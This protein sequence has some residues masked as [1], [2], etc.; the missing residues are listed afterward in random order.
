MGLDFSDLIGLALTLLF[1][2][3]CLKPFRKEVIALF[4]TLMIGIV[5][6]SLRMRMRRKTVRDFLISKLGPKR[7]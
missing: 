2:Q 1:L 6:S 7:L 4:L 3:M 5:L